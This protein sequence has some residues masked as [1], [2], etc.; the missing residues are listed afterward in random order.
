MSDPAAGQNLRDAGSRISRRRFTQRAAVAAAL[1]LSPTE[2]FAAAHHNQAAPDK[3]PSLTPDQTQEVEV[4][5]ANIIRKYGSR[6]S[7]E[8]RQHLRRIL[9]Y[10]E[11]MLASVRAFP[12]QNGD[13]PAS[14]LK[15]SFASGNNTGSARKSGEGKS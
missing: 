15:V 6:L 4:R 9:T 7:E 8:Q 10:N 2:F 3:A 14:V 1:S 11:R 13:P 5:L 12:L